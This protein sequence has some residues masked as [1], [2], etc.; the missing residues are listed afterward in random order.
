[1]VAVLSWVYYRLSEA[2]VPAQTMSRAEEGSLTLE[3]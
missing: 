3:G 1:M 2:G